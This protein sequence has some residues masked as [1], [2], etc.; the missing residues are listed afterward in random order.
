MTSLWRHQVTSL[1]PRFAKK[2]P[3]FKR[4]LRHEGSILEKIW[5][6]YQGWKSSELSEWPW[7]HLAISFTFRDI[8]AESFRNFGNRHFGHFWKYAKWRNAEQPPWSIPGVVELVY[9]GKGLLLC[10][11]LGFKWNFQTARLR[12]LRK[13]TQK[14]LKLAKTVKK[15]KLWTTIVGSFLVR[16]SW[17]FVGIESMYRPTTMPSFK[18]LTQK[19]CAQC[20]CKIARA[21]KYRN[22]ELSLW[23]HF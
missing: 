19:L 21:A 11:R 2:W 23:A 7:V 18:F 4:I 1:L 17:N 15:S 16:S 20:T 3:N 10:I 13:V 14:S 8:S 6:R 5:C 9:N 12:D 22:F